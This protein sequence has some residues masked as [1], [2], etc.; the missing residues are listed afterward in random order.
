MRNFS[1]NVHGGGDGGNPRV[2]GTGSLREIGEDR[3]EGGRWET[4]GG[5]AGRN[6][7]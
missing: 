4:Q 1:K 6:R 5:G 7:K 3:G 2:M